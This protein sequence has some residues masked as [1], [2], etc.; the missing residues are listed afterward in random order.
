[1]TLRECIVKYIE[2]KRFCF[3]LKK[4]CVGMLGAMMISGTIAGTMP[5]QAGAAPAQTS[6]AQPAKVQQTEEPLKISINLAARSLALLKGTE[7]VRL[8]PI[9]PGKVSTPTPT[10]YYKV[11]SKDVNPTWTDPDTGY[12]IA[13]GPS[14]PLG[15]RWMQ[16]QGNYGIHGTNKPDSIGHYVSNGC[17]RMQEADVEALFDMVEVG[18]PIEIT[19]NRVVVEKAPDDTVVYYIYPDRYGWQKLNAG[20]VS[21]WLAGY[22]VENFVADADIEAKL[23]AS[24]GNPTYIAKVYPLYVN[25]TKLKNKAIVQNGVTYLPA[26]DLAD[27]VKVNLGWDEKTSTLATTLGKTAG[28]NKKDVLYCMADD[29]STLFHLTGTL[30]KDKTY[31]MLPIQTATEA[32]PAPAAAAAASTETVNTAEN[33]QAKPAAQAVSSKSR[34]NTEK[35]TTKAK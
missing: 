2:E 21:K 8:Y 1:M 15:Y 33:E 11:L 3:M 32:D 9:A 16:F 14:N 35:K 30:N 22:G 18:T 20:D 31:T 6:T 25:G 17:I 5:L 10:G 19:Y 13:S 7:K 26:I 29:T 28:F 4:V 24:D 12:S 23:T 34:N 27:A